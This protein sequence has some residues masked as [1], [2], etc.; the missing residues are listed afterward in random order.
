VS[1]NEIISLLY[2]SKPF[3]NLVKRM[4]PDH[5]RQDL[6]QETIMILLEMPEE[7][8]ISLNKSGGLFYYCVRVMINLVKNKSSR[9]NKL[10]LTKTTDKIPERQYF[11]QEVNG[12]EKEKRALT[13]FENLY[14][15][16]K[17][18]SKLY[19]GLG[20]YRAVEEETRIPRVSVC[21]T[22]IGAIK[23]VRDAVVE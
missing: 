12:E 15:Y 2:E 23:K 18:I 19:F 20:S 1:K 22:V 4:E 3:K 10:Y 16:E 5:L 14:W 11:D 8:I 7:K 9:F 6:K 13:A 21:R 17:E